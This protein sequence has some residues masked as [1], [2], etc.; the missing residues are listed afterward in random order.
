ME[1]W[2][3]G[4]QR[5]RARDP[6]V[7]KMQ[8]E[9]P[10]GTKDVGRGKGWM[11][12]TSGVRRSFNLQFR[13]VRLSPRP[14]SGRTAHHCSTGLI[15]DALAERKMWE[16][17]PFPSFSSSP[18]CPSPIQLCCSHRPMKDDGLHAE[19]SFPPHPHSIQLLLLV[20]FYAICLLKPQT[21][22]SPSS[23]SQNG[24]FIG[25]S[26]QDSRG[27]S[28]LNVLAKQRTRLN[29]LDYKKD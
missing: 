29:C 5:Y 19:R 25:K 9:G 4:Y 14:P 17:P 8:G 13:A 23:S 7:L 12:Q 3:L 18:S 1:R 28:F 22:I 27:K 10:S 11:E 26:N 16:I 21:N 6:Q 24:H 2:T 15:R 20:Y